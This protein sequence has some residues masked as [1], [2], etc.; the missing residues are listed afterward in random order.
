MGAKE[1]LAKKKAAAAARK[2]AKEAHADAAPE[3]KKAEPSNAS[4]ND[5]LADAH[6]DMTGETFAE[7][8]GMPA[9]A[10]AKKLAQ[11]KSRKAKSSYPIFYTKKGQKVLKLIAKPGKTV[12]VYIGNLSPKKHK[13]ALESLIKKWKEDG[14]WL[15]EHQ[16]KEKMSAIQAEYAAKAVS[17]KG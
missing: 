6:A 7:A 5:V 13:V 1:E 10:H 8:K 3:K 2:A 4:V 9:N 17:K 16:A 12:S 11:E 14:I 15:E